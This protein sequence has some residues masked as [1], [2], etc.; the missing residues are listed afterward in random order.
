M[1]AE[2]NAIKDSLEEMRYLTES[3]WAKLRNDYLL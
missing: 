3:K 2:K 1:P